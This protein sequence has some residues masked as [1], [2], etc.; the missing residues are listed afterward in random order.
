MMELGTELTDDN[1]QV[2]SLKEKSTDLLQEIKRIDEEINTIL[3]KGY[4]DTK[5]EYKNT[6]EANLIRKNYAG[7]KGHLPKLF[8]K[9]T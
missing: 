5:K 2:S 6:K 4:A 7:G 1:S 3:S 9:K 8:D